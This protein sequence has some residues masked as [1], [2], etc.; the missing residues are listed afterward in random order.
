[1]LYKKNEFEQ[2]GF[3]H[4]H[5]F[6]IPAEEKEPIRIKS[7]S[8]FLGSFEPIFDSKPEG[9]YQQRIWPS[10]FESKIGQNNSKTRR[11]ILF[12]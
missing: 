12:G 6:F 5:S 7:F 9:Q 11:K 1:L 4:L 2:S 8:R 3:F 10:D